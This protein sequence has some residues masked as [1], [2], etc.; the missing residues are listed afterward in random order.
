MENEFI[1]APL[2]VSRQPPSDPKDDL[3]KALELK[4]SKLKTELLKIQR[5]VEEKF[6]GDGDEEGPKKRESI[7]QWEENLDVL[8]K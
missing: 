6:E 4:N 5:A 2:L 8:N 7:F 3:I 1:N